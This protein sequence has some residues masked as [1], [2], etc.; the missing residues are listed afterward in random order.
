MRFGMRTIWM[1]SEKVEISESNY[2]VQICIDGKELTN[3]CGIIGF[4]F[5][6]I[7]YD[8]QMILIV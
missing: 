1:D 8:E 6:E 5:R 4:Q 3:N 2:A 7:F